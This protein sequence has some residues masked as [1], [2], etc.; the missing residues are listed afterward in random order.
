[1]QQE[2]IRAHIEAQDKLRQARG[3]IGTSGLLAS[4]LRASAWQLI[5]GE[6]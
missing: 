1:M 3:R 5:Y 2:V 6:V 4:A